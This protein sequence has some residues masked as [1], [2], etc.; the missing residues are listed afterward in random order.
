MDGC[1]KNL[2]EL[3]SQDSKDSGEKV[4]EL[5]PLLKELVSLYEYDNVDYKKTLVEYNRERA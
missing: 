1:F 5:P 3:F 4:L 2:K